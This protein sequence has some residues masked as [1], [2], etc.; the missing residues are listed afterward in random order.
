MSN[1]EILSNFYLEVKTSIENGTFSKLTFAKTIGNTQLMNIYV[2]VIVE[3]EKLVL[4]LKYKFQ[5]DEQIEVYGIDKAFDVLTN[6]VSN[7]FQSL[8]LFTCE[9]DLTLKINKKRDYK[10]NEQAPTFKNAADV[11]LAFYKNK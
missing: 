9:K 7:P 1:A 3:N 4:E 11:I 5:Q 6:Y 8:L 2:R 10:L